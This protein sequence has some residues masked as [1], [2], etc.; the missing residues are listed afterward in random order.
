MDQVSPSSTLNILEELCDDAFPTPLSHKEGKTEYPLH[1]YLG[2][3]IPVDRLE[4]EREITLKKAL[5]MIKAN[6]TS[7]V[8]RVDGIRLDFNILCQDLQK[9]QEQQL[10]NRSGG[11]GATSVWQVSGVRIL[12]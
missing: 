10:W 3:T 6:H 9:I 2:P 4:R 1:L 12:N 11:P 7:F 5:C 8:R